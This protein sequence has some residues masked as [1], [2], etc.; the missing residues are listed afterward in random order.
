M[1]DLSIMIATLPIIYPLILKLGFSPSGLE[2][3]MVQKILKL[4]LSALP[5]ASE[6]LLSS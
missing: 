6:T 5:M 4:A 2:Y 3:L 1:D